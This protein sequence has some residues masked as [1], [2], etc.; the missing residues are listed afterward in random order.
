M[1]Q[2]ILKYSSGVITICRDLFDYVNTLVPDR[3]SILIENVIDYGHMYKIIVEIFNLA[4]KN[5][6]HLKK[7]YLNVKFA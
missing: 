1:E 6:A 7:L 4:P 3:G 5:L 2:W